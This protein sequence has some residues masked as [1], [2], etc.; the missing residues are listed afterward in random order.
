MVNGQKNEGSYTVAQSSLIL[1]FGAGEPRKFNFQLAGDVLSLENGPRL[2]RKKAAPS[3]GQDIFGQGQGPIQGPS[4]QASLE[5]AWVAG[6]GQT[7]VIMMFSK[8]ICGLTI[9]GQQIFGPYSVEGNI[10]K[11]QFN[12]GRVLNLAFS[13]DGNTLRLAD[14]TVLIRQNLPGAMP[15]PQFQGPS[16]P[17]PLEGAWSTSL[18]NGFVLTFVFQG[19]SYTCYNNGQ[20]IEAGNFVLNGPRLEFTVTFGQNQG[21]S[22]VNFWAVEGQVLILTLANGQKIALQKQS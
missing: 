14:G 15:E 1:R 12:N 6:D 10:L 7:M 16:G 20:K 3:Q 11:V 2:L 8:G 13:I 5:G 21:Q 18:P 22:G 9:N 17:S 4:A 19:Q